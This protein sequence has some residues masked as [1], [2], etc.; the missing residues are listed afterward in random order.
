MI[1]ALQWLA[2]VGVHVALLAIAALI[3]TKPE[4]KFSRYAKASGVV[5]KV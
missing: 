4:T 2:F 1:E 3:P 5:K